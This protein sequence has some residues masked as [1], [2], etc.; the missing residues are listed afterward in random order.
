MGGTIIGVFLIQAFNT[1]LTMVNVPSFW[2]Y[3]AKG[4]LLLFALTSDFIRKRNRE[5]QLLEASKKNG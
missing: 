2:Q 5:K 3:V 4:A 1:G